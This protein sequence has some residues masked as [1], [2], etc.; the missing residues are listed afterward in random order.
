MANRIE[1]W[2]KNVWSY[3]GWDD[4]LALSLMLIGLLGYFDGPIPYMPKL[5]EIYIDNRSELIGMG[6]GVLI[7]ANAGEVVSRWQEKKR[8]ILQMGSPDN[9]FAREAVRQLRS[10]N[11]L[12]DGSLKGADLSE[13]DLT[14]AYL[15]KVNLIKAN[16]SAATLRGADLRC[17]D[18][19]GADLLNA[20]LSGADM[21][22]WPTLTST[23]LT[24]AY[25]DK[26]TIWPE[27]FDPE[28]AEAI[29]V[30]DEGNPVTDE[31]E[32]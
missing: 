10:K 28:A 7:I 15:V 13:A 31:Q 19:S 30:D 25:Y 22:W 12:T 11:C 21:S 24:G 9:A 6:F 32:A 17:A 2:L 26:E 5:D 29:L 27:G 14:N 1:K 4:Y 23:S 3:V 20:N 16:L 18:L 8:L